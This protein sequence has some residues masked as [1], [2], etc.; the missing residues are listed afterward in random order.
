M[1][2]VFVSNF[3]NH[4][5]I[6]ICEEYIR[7]SDE[8][9]FIATESSANQGFQRNTEKE[10]VVHYDLD[11][12]REIAIKEILDADI[13]VMGA[14]PDELIKLRADTKKSTFLY[15]ERFFKKGLWRRFIP[16]TR[17]KIYDKV[18]KYK[19]YDNF[20]LLSASA[21]LPYELSL[22]GF[23][24]S[25]IFKWGYFPRFVEYENIE[26]VISKKK[27]NSILWAGR[28]L[29]LK[30]PEYAILLARKLKSSNIEFEL[31]MIGDGE[32][33]DDI[34]KLINKYNLQNSVRL[35]GGQDTQ[36]VRRFMENSEIFLFTS[37]KMEGW[38]AV[39]NEAMNSGCAVVAS[40]MIG[41]V[42]FL[43][44]DNVNGAV[45]ESGNVDELYLKVKKLLEDDGL[46]KTY[47][48]NAYENIK[49]NWNHKVAAERLVKLYNSD[50]SCLSTLFDEGVCS[51]AG[52]IK[53]K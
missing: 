31:T 6:P 37:N 45:F 25:K 13:A 35:M 34:E 43:I 5:Q 27:K 9:Y 51:L 4:H 22:L 41:A 2:I 29:R 18:L 47:G 52:V 15:S 10:Y 11:R 24:V 46:R 42:P 16:T 7:L 32:C 30:H 49:N 50:I 12:E 26:E 1:K 3:L 19:D 28:F 36:K 21:Y 14:C 33:F 8:F 53:G 20:Y 17:K 39:L 23:P 48:I 40:N 38:G 44:D